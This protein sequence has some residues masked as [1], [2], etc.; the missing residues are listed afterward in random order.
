MSHSPGNEPHIPNP[1]GGDPRRPEPGS[2]QAFTRA[3]IQMAG[4]NAVLL[5]AAVLAVYV[6][7]VVD[8]EVGIWVIVAA[9]VLAGV[10]ASATVLRHQRQQS[11]RHQGQHAGHH[12][13]QGVPH[14]RPADHAAHT[15]SGAGDSRRSE[16]GAVG[17]DFTFEVDD[18]FA[19]IGRGTVVTG[20]VRSGQVEVGQ[21]V[22]FTRDGVVVARSS[23]TGIERAG[24]AKQAQPGRAEAGELVGIL[25][26]D[27]D[28]SQIEK[29]DILGP[30]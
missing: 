9:A 23:V 29:G 17:Q 12:Q 20:T 10:N 18:R 19:I 27:V 25:L 4:I 22:Q 24:R 1:L 30:G 15:T 6:F 8:P 3:I 14:P 2:P 11:L 13:G 28:R 21:G 5:V 16:P 26:A 7:E